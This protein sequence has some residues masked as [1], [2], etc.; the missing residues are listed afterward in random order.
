LEEKYTALKRSYDNLTNE[1]RALATKSKA[2]APATPV[3]KKKKYQNPE[4]KEAEG[5][6]EE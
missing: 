6:D 1:V 5:G 2:A 3:K 4:A